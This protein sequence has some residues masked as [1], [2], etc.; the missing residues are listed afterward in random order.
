[1]ADF[2][3]QSSLSLQYHR[4]LE[5]LVFFNARQ[6]DAQSGIARAV[7]AYGTP[8]IVASTDGLRLVVSRRDDVQC[9]FALAPAGSALELAGM[10]LY[11]RTCEEEVTLLHISVADRY[12][13]N[14]RAG[15]AAVIALVRAVRAS[16]HR[17]R[18]V[19]RLTM[20]YLQGRQFQ[21]P[22]GASA[23]AEAVAVLEQGVPVH[24]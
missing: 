19:R 3:M 16:A 21:V 8:A 24:G 10:V 12:A 9:L 13:R 15:L 7:D 1:M 2:V 20:V 23:G 6:R 4:S 17:L 22:L 5:K 14:G 11:L 18:G